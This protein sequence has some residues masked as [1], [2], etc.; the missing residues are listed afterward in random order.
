LNKKKVVKKRPAKKTAAKKAT[1]KTAS[2]AKTPVVVLQKSEAQAPASPATVDPDEIIRGD[3]NLAE[4]A[5]K[6]ARG[7][8]R[9]WKDKGLPFTLCPKDGV[10]ALYV[11]GDCIEWCAARGLNFFDKA[12]E[13]TPVQQEKYRQERFKANELEHKELIRTKQFDSVS[14]F[15]RETDKMLVQL[16][17]LMI[18][19]TTDIKKA[20]GL[21]GKKAEE[22]DAKLAT[23]FNRIAEMDLD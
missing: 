15:E 11:L 6:R 23:G 18:E 10:T 7:S 14:K 13:L 1:K 5:D 2:K 9:D 21:K 16:K 17:S 19:I 20:A 22:I 3:R 4:R 12:K 8:I